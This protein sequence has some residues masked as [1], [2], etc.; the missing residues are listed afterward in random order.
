MKAG[1][2]LFEKLADSSSEVEVSQVRRVSEGSLT[3]E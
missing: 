2:L 1:Y 3:G